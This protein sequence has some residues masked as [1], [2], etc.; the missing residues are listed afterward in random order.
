MTT[1]NNDYQFTLLAQI[2]YQQ[3]CIGFYEKEKINEKRNQHLKRWSYYP[4][5]YTHL[6]RSI[7]MKKKINNDYKFT[8]LAQIICQQ[9]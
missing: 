3:L 1:F 2:V 7:L 5:S 4:F 9:L 6:T 8:L